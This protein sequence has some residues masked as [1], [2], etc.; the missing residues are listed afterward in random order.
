MIFTWIVAETAARAT[1][2]TL[3]GRCPKCGR[4]QVVPEGKLSLEVK[5]RRCGARV[6]PAAESKSKRRRS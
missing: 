2:E 6:P 3:T 4:K 1:L 5:C